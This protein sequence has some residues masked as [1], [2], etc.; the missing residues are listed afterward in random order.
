MCLKVFKEN[1]IEVL[2]NL[3]TTAEF[4]ILM[5]R[6]SIILWFDLSWGLCKIQCTTSRVYLLSTI[7]FLLS[8][9]VLVQLNEF[10]VKKRMADAAL[11]LWVKSFSP[12]WE[13]FRP[14]NNPTIPSKISERQILQGSQILKRIW[15]TLWFFFGFFNSILSKSCEAKLIT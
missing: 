8:M 13:T 2:W 4:L 9:F 12:L 5:F 1:C 6:R 15:Q 11:F 14:K 3:L 7:F 10:S